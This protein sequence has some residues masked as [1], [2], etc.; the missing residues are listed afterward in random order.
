[1]HGWAQHP[2]DPSGAG[3]GWELCH[4]LHTMTVTHWDGRGEGGQPRGWLLV[5]TCLALALLFF[6]SAWGIMSCNYQCWLPDKL[7]CAPAFSQDEIPYFVPTGCQGRGAGGCH[8]Y[9]EEREMG[10]K[11]EKA[12]L[13]IEVLE[14]RQAWAAPAM[15]R[16]TPSVLWSG[17]SSSHPLGWRRPTWTLGTAGPQLLG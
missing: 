17:L 3:A 7:F 6:V 8:P 11:G 4:P 16:R 12:Y 13:F 5:G 15:G 14:G 2:W 1:M 9:G 10:N